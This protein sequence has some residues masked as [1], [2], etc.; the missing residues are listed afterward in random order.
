MESPRAAPPPPA[1][2]QLAVPSVSGPEIARLLVGQS[3]GVGE[4]RIQLAGGIFAGAS[5]HLV[6]APGGLEARL[7]APTEAARAAL[8]SVLDRV[9]H[10]LRSRGI[11]MRPGAPLDTGSRQ[12]QRD[13]RERR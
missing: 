12:R 1:A 4:A 8:A 2:R 13:G 11:V 9:G 5:I 10:H 6:T 3:H 7:G